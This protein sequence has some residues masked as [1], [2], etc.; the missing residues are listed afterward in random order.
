MKQP[1]DI[2]LADGR[3][4]PLPSSRSTEAVEKKSVALCACYCFV[5]FFFHRTIRQNQD[6]CCTV[7][8]VLCDCSLRVCIIFFFF[9]SFANQ[10]GRSNVHGEL[11]CH[12]RFLLRALEHVSSKG[13]PLASG[14]S[15]VCCSWGISA[16]RASLFGSPGCRDTGMKGLASLL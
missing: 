1:D 11:R 7:S 10:Q 4:A 14:S 12:L 15:S 8:V 3:Y 6:R 13:S 2:R 16:G 5:D 9:S